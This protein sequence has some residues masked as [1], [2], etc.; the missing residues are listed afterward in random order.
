[1]ASL[2]IPYSTKLWREK[3]LADLVVHCQSAKVLSANQPSNF[4]GFYSSLPIRQRFLCQ[5]SCSSNSA[6]VFFSQSFVLYGNIIRKIVHK[7]MKHTNNIIKTFEVDMQ[8][9]LSDISI[10]Y[11]EFMKYVHN[12]P[13]KA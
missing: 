13:C 1:M 5:F 3:T 2:I 4:D 11:S 7:W 8:G 6:K 10:I 9:Y 12:P